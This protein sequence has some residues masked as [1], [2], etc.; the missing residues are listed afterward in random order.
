M[1]LC[2]CVCVCVCVSLE[3][4]LSDKKERKNIYIAKS[5]KYQLTLK[6]LLLC[7]YVN[8][9][10]FQ[11]LFLAGRKQ[12]QHQQ[13]FENNNNSK[14]YGFTTSQWGMIEVASFYSLCCIFRLTFGC[15]T[16]QTLV[17]ICYFNWLTS[18]LVQPLKNVLST[19]FCCKFLAFLA[20]CR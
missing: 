8:N 6:A 18:V 14:I 16:L 17:K 9:M 11:N 10:Q 15:C 20:F 7:K 3:N 19:K 4:N 2:V 5:H 13:Q 12:L 1:C